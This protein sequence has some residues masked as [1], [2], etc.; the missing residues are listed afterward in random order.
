MA[1]GIGLCLGAWYLKVTVVSYMCVK[2]VQYLMLMK[3]SGVSKDYE[4]T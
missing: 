4:R 2:T 3:L 1:C